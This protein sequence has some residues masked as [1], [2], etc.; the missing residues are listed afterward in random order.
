MIRTEKANVSIIQEKLC[1]SL[2]H[3]LKVESY[4]LTALQIP[5]LLVDLLNA[6]SLI[7]SSVLLL[8]SEKNSLAQ[9]VGDVPCFCPPNE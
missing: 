7:L 9:P 4:L 3:S 6:K 8:A 5:L 2:T 1:I